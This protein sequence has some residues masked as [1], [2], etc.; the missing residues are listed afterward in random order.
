MAHMHI[1]LNFQQRQI[2]LGNKA[3]FPIQRGKHPAIPLQDWS[4]VLE[5]KRSNWWTKERIKHLASA[6]DLS[7]QFLESV[8]KCSRPQQQLFQ[9]DPEWTLCPP[10]EDEE[11]P[12]LLRSADG[13][14]QHD[15]SSSEAESEY[16]EVW[17]QD[18]EE[19]VVDETSHDEYMPRKTVPSSNG[20]EN[21]ESDHQ[22]VYVQLRSE[23][24]T[25]G[26]K[27]QRRL[28][29][30]AKNMNDGEKGV[31]QGSTDYSSSKQQKIVRKQPKRKIGNLLVLAEAFLGLCTLIANSSWQ[32]HQPSLS[33]TKET[34]ETWQ[35]VPPDLLVMH[36]DEDPAA[37]PAVKGRQ[38]QH[39]VMMASEAIEEQHA[40]DGLYIMI[41]LYQ[42]KA[43]DMWQSWRASL[44]TGR[45]HLYEYIG[46]G[47]LV[48]E[49]DEVLKRSVVP[50]QELTPRRALKLL[51]E[52]VLQ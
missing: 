45:W 19:I 5:K 24:K 7:Q 46:S 43:H 36:M 26:K 40:R 14:R 1:Q 51:C 2:Q 9:G 4:M 34:L 41:K 42:H 6:Y 30:K 25:L 47:E 17:T 18:E 33:I 39:R 37:P 28:R 35:G 16:F 31:E 20:E 22:P 10:G 49:L 48:Q 32:C 21:E 23:T 44:A 12:I 38:A 11:L 3:G 29:Q 52:K 13:K 27:D 50:L 15:S 8:S